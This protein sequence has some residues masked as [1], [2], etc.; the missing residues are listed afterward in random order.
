MEGLRQLRLCFG[1]VRRRERD[2]YGDRKK[3]TEP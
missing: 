3:A 2:V 1:I